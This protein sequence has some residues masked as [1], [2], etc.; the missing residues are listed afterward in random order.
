MV[1]LKA[2]QLELVYKNY[3]PTKLQDYW[4]GKII[5]FQDS[6]GVPRFIVTFMQ[7]S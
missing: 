1:T 4:F 6:L 5:N 7:Q 3:E 2:F